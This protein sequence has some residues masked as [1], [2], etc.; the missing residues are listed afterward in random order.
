MRHEKELEDKDLEWEGKVREVENQLRDKVE[1]IDQL[2]ATLE[3]RDNTILENDEQR[4]ELLEQ[5]EDA[6]GFERKL[7][8][9]QANFDDFKE[10]HGDAKMDRILENHEQEI[11]ELRAKYEKEAREQSDKIIELL[12]QVEDDTHLKKNKKLMKEVEELQEQ[13]EEQRDEHERST[14]KLRKD[15]STHKDAHDKLREEVQKHKSTAD[16]QTRQNSQLQQMLNQQ[17]MQNQMQ[18]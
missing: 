13:L 17:Q 6:K 14:K 18:R 2:Q 12:E 9:V 7:K 10:A 1:E 4:A 8:R 11:E 5:L 15:L 3:R 16:Q